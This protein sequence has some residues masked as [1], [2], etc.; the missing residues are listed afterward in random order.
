MKRCLF[1]LLTCASGAWVHA[2]PLSTQKSLEVL[3]RI[4]AAAKNLNYSGAYVYQR[5]A[6]IDTY[7][8]VHIADEKG[9]AERRESLDGPPKVMLR[10]GEKITCYLPDAKYVNLDRHSVTKL[11]PSLLPEN[12]PDLLKVYAVIPSG[13]ERVAAL[14]AKVLLLEP[15]DALRYP[16]KLWYDPNSGLLL[17]AAM[18]KGAPEQPTEQFSFTQ[19]QIGGVIS[20]KQLQTKLRD[21]DFKSYAEMQ[22]QAQVNPAAVEWTLKS[23]PSGFRLVKITKRSSESGALTHMMFSDGLSIVSLFI[24][25]LLANQKPAQGLSVKETTYLYAK[26]LGNFQLTVLGDAP[27]ATVMQFANSVMPATLR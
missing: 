23:V 11:F 14:D 7:Q 25:P 22:M 13:E 21:Q 19:V 9:E 27:E 16:Y 8:L 6:H 5:G 17:K 3:N 18:L 1:L 4:A 26:A 20:R 10:E 2:E 24:E 12:L 15:K